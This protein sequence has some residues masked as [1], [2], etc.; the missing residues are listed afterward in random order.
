MDYD[1]KRK[2]GAAHGVCLSKG[3]IKQVY[4]N[5]DAKKSIPYIFLTLCIS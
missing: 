2:G 4:T 3:I 5:Y 1:V